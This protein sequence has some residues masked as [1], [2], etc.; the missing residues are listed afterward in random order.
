MPA[1]FDNCRVRGGRIVTVAGPS[2]KY[3]LKAGEYMH[4]CIL[5]GEFNRGEVKQKEKK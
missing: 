5:K 2:K 3:G 4:I 1:A